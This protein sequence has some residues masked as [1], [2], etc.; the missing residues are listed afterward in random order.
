MNFKYHIYVNLEPK[1]KE[2]KLTEIATAVRDKAINPGD[3]FLIEHRNGGVAVVA[4]EV[5]QLPGT[6]EYN[7]IG[8]IH[9]ACLVD[10]PS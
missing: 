3:L 6:N 8:A 10:N 1:D 9:P 2:P 5:N 7:I 4:W